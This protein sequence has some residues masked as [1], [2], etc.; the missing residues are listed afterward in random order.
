MAVIVEHYDLKEFALVKPI[1]IA[2]LPKPTQYPPER[3]VLIS[4]H[5]SNKSPFFVAFEVFVPLT[6]KLPPA[7]HFY[8]R[9][10]C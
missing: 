6:E 7:L 4:E 2:A 10:L 1:L 9:P 8:H 5:R 3:T